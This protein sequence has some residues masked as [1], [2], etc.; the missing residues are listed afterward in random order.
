MKRL[1]YYIFGTVLLPG[2]TLA[3][4]AESVQLH[5][6]KPPLL[7]NGLL[8]DG[9]NLNFGRVIYY[10]PHSG[11]RLWSDSHKATGKIN[12]YILNGS[13]S[14]HNKIRV[15]IVSEGGL[16]DAVTGNGIFISETKTIAPFYIV[17]DGDQMISSDTYSFDLKA[18]FTQ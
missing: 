15:R 4:S 12:S 16:P 9:T 3:H 2:V 17:A 5:L 6:K 18:D 7:Q 13:R 11:F 14:A 8:K 10:G 1:L